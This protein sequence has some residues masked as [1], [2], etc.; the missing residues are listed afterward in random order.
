[1]VV[2]YSDGSSRLM[3]AAQLVIEGL[4]R[5]PGWLCHAGTELISI[6]MKGDIHKGLCRVDGSIGNIAAIDRFELPE[7]PTLCTRPSCNC[8]LDIMTSR[9]LPHQSLP[10]RPQPSSVA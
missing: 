9:S 10:R 7:R 1:M 5:W 3:S 2:S 6:D 4:N 8:L